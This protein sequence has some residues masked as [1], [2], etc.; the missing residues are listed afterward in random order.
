MP[1]APLRAFVPTC[2]VDSPSDPGKRPQHLPRTVILLGWVSFFADVS[3]EL[4]YPL[5]P[6]FV[7]VVLGAGALTLTGIEGAAEALVSFMRAFAGWHSDASGRRTPWVR[8]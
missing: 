2:L 6:G 7:T 3:S 1:P 5:L 8:G 4:V